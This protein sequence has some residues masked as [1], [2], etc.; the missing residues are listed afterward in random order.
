VL[1]I[2]PVFDIRKK[3]ETKNEET[4]KRRNEKNKKRIR[5]TRKKAS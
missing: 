4:K 1:I 5:I 2:A 3:E